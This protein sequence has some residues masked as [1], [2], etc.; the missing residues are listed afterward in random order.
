MEIVICLIG[1]IL[2]I[3]GC[4]FSENIIAKIG[5]GIVYV[6]MILLSAFRYDGTDVGIYMEDYYAVGEYSWDF[7]ND[8]LGKVTQQFG[9]F[10]FSK[11]LYEMDLNF[12]YMHFYL[13][14][15]SML[16]LGWIVYRIIF[17]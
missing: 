8:E 5:G 14:L 11:L 9:F 13:I 12:A 6:L 1:V 15:L 10:Y 2:L 17:K 16:L 7:W 4:Y 3:I